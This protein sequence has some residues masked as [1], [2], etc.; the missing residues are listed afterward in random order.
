MTCLTPKWHFDIAGVRAVFRG[1]S[2]T[3]LM[4]AY[5]SFVSLVETPMSSTFCALC[6]ALIALSRCFPIEL[7]NAG[8]YLLKHW[9][10][11]AICKS[12]THKVEESM[13]SVNLGTIS[14]AE[15]F[16][17]FSMCCDASNKVLTE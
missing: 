8:R 7:E 2:K 4:L 5:T 16:F 10:K 3:G 11:A 14:F 12:S 9:R 13:C 17:S 6:S 1:P 15:H